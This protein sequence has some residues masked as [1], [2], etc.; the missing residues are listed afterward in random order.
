MSIMQT[1]IQHQKV[2]DNLRLT[3]F[4][5]IAILL[6]CAAAGAM[7]KVVRADDKSSYRK[8]AVCKFARTV[9]DPAVQTGGRLHKAHL[10]GIFSHD[11]DIDAGAETADGFTL[12]R[13]KEDW[14]PYIIFRDG[15]GPE[16]AH[17]GDINGDGCNDIVIGGWSN[18]LLWAE[19]PAGSGADPY[20]TPWKIHIVDKSRWCHDTFPVDMD[21]DGK[22][23][24]VTNEG[25]YFQGATP[26]TWTF[27]DIGRGIKSVGTAVGNVLGNHDGYNDIV[28]NYQDAGHNQLCWFENP[29]HTGGNPRTDVWN[30]HVID[31]MPGGAANV[32]ANTM[33]FALGDLDG[34]KRPDLV[35]AFQGEGP[36]NKKSQIGDGLVWYKAPKNPRNGVWIKTV[37]DP[38][39]SYIHTSSIQLA[40]FNGSGWLDICYAQQEQ[41][42]PCPWN[43]A[44]GEKEGQPRQQVGI[45]YNGGHARSWTRQILTEYPD[46]AAGGFNSKVMKIGDDRYP[47]ILTANHG[48]FGQPNP[49]VLFRNLGP[50]PKQKQ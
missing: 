33:S 39:L 4:I 5:A 8:S 32:N 19:N 44:G 41:S 28:A 46:E 17:P 31:D 36:D 12:Y 24:I 7:T 20:T 40:D 50:S 35:A 1:P 47:S 2:P 26:D 23:D 48:A 15:T 13:S 22:C 3:V 14:K 16:D 10:L 37:I 25:I 38:N 18:Q 21:K 49:I 34:D 29:G 42:G 11:N 6:L 43:G 9:I 27:K 30:I 45:F